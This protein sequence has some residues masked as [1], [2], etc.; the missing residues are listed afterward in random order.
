MMKKSA[1]YTDSKDFHNLIKKYF[2]LTTK[3]AIL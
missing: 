2:Y 1:S 3:A